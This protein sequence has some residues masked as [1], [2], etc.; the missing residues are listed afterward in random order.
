MVAGGLCLSLLGRVQLHARHTRSLSAAG[1]LVS[2]SAFDLSFLGSGGGNST[3]SSAKSTAN[4]SRDVP[5][6]PQSHS[7]VGS[8]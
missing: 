3:F 6:G 7:L 4:K 1:P 8:A 2:G 5:R